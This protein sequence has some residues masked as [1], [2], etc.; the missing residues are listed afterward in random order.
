ML[1]HAWHGTE[2][3]RHDTIGRSKGR[4]RIDFLE[5]PLEE[6]P[7]PSQSINFRVPGGSKPLSPAR[8]PRSRTN[9][10]HKASARLSGSFDRSSMLSRSASHQT[11][12]LSTS[13]DARLRTPKLSLMSID[14][15]TGL[16]AG[17]YLLLAAP[18]TS[19]TLNPVSPVPSS[20]QRGGFSRG[21]SSQYGAIGGKGG[22]GGLLPFPNTTPSGSGQHVKRTVSSQSRNVEAVDEEESLPQ[23]SAPTAAETI[24][25]PVAE[26]TATEG[27]E[28]LTSRLEEHVTPTPSQS[29]SASGTST[30]TRT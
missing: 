22:V 16:S 29:S 19:F 13:S 7:G 27:G 30:P 20:A 12:V 6:S 11:S 5:P 10:P 26:T 23:A 9:S 4:Q 14:R 21:M 25:T 3:G 2:R 24:V 15:P 1:S 8:R 18:P 28:N 17:H